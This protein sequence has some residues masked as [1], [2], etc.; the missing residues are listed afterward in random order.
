[1]AMTARLH[2]FWQNLLRRDE[3]KITEAPSAAADEPRRTVVESVDISPNDPLAAYFQSNPGLVQ[4]DR[5]NLDSPALSSLKAAGVKISIPLVSH[6]ELIGLLNLG[7]RL[8]EQDY[9]ADDHKLLND[10]AVQAAPALRVAQLV[11]QQQLEARER[12]RIDQELRVA[13]VI[14][15][16]LLPQHVPSLEGW[17]IATYYQPARE[18]GGDFYDFLEL[19][20]GRLG[21]I[22]ADVTDKGIPA[23]LV[24]ATTRSILRSSAERLVSP[25]K[26]LQRVNNLLVDDIPPNMFVTCFYAVLDPVSG[27][28]QYANAGH[29]LPYRR[30]SNGV[31]ELKAKG[32]PLGLMPDMTYDEEEVTLAPGETIL[33]HS[34]GLVEAHNNQRDMFGFPRLQGLVGSHPGGEALIGFLLD[35]LAEFTG[36]DWEQEDDVTL[37]MLQR[38]DMS[39]SECALSDGEWRILTEFTVPSEPGN[40]RI[41]M[42]KIAEGVQSLNLPQAM[43]ENLKT[44]VSEATMNAM[45]HGNKYDPELPVSIELVA[46]D[47]AIAVRITDQGGDQPIVETEAPDIEAKLAGEQSPRGWGL[48]LIKNLV[49][50][51]RVSHDGTHH[52]VELVLNLK[53]DKG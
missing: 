36:D 17:Q 44:A 30:T 37:V 45:E 51:M 3:R 26:V 14:Q 53:G 18:V 24:M 19:P 49:D 1:M 21:L 28:L 22:I 25:G 52:T 40:E 23:A 2:T 42:N 6:G 41:A 11:R 12:E 20:E 47:T 34:D 48:F 50:E 38:S 5:L 7:P 8:S 13:R 4:V 46:S 10:L 27:L 29:D 32:M 31:T 33:F 16:T 39:D 15:Q 43:L 35:H 9:S